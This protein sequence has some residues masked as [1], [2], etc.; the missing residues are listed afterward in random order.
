ME[1]LRLTAECLNSRK[2]SQTILE[3]F[4]VAKFLFFCLAFA[5]QMTEIVFEALLC[6]F[7]GKRDFYFMFFDV[8]SEVISLNL[9]WQGLTNKND[10]QSLFLN[11]EI[12]I[13]ALPGIKNR[14]FDFLEFILK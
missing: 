8:C 13:S 2:M 6:R 1:A 11:N 5:D 10:L 3:Q 9:D 7:K 12:V 4:E 14:A